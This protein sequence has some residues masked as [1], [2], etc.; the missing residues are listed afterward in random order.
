MDAIT[1]AYQSAW[2]QLIKPP[3]MV[4]ADH[5]IGPEFLAASAGERIRRQPFEVLNPQE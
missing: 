2:E 1:R 4:Y 3:P 5:D